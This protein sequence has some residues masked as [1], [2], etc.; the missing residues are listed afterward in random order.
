[1][2]RKKVV[3]T[4]RSTSKTRKRAKSTDTSKLQ[5]FLVPEHVKLT[6]KERDELFKTYNV[7]LKEMPKIFASDPA[8]RHLG[9]KENDVIKI[10]RK[11]PTAG[12]TVFY[13]GVINE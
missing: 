5:H 7:T 2:A 11:S 10:V 9:V 6:Q 4:T 13:R 3:R 12:T 1:M 8:I